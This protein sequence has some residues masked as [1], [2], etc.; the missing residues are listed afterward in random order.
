MLT[1][2]WR[3]SLHARLTPGCRFLSSAWSSSTKLPGLLSRP[4]IPLLLL[5]F[6]PPPCLELM[7]LVGLIETAPVAVMMEEPSMQQLEFGFCVL[8]CDKQPIAGLDCPNRAGFGVIDVK[9]GSRPMRPRQASRGTE[10]RAK[11]NQLRCDPV[12]LLMGYKERT[13]KE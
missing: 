12:S 10:C 2:C 3:H 11:Q 5:R 8:K 4:P 6:T 7:G 1:F 13:W 9:S